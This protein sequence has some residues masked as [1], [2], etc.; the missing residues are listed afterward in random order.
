MSGDVVRIAPKPSSKPSVLAGPNFSPQL[1]LTPE[2]KHP[3]RTAYSSALPETGVFVERNSTD[4]RPLETTVPN[5]GKNGGISVRLNKP[6]VNSSARISHKLQMLQE[7]KFNSA[8]AIAAEL[9]KSETTKTALLERAAL[10]VNVK[11]DQNKYSDLVPLDLVAE[12]LIGVH[13]QQRASFKPREPKV[14]DNEPQ[15]MDFFSEEFE[16]ETSRCVFPG[17]EE[18]DNE[19]D[20][21]DDGGG[22]G[23]AFD[24]YRHV[25]CW[26]HSWR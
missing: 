2:K 16:E 20:D 11:R 10:G 19:V 25:Q 9:E 7:C 5:K 1:D 18:V 13:T 24:L 14:P 3:K 26:E 6:C 21:D 8:I 22:G 4:I 23:H 15:I 17:P 12:D